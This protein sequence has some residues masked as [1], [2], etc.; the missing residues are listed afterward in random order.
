M[1]HSVCPAVLFILAPL[2]RAYCGQVVAAYVVKPDSFS[3]TTG[4]LKLQCLD[5]GLGL[6]LN[7]TG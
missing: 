1:W 7:N 6:D 3:V 2:E 4:L 5:Q